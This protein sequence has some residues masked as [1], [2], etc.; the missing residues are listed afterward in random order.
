VNAPFFSPVDSY[1][2]ARGILGGW[3]G[4][5]YNAQGPRSFANG[6]QGA[7]QPTRHG[8]HPKEPSF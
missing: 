8:F 3:P 2:R 1:T 7:L 4:L 6:S 5:F